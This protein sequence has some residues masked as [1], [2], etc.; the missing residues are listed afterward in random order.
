MLILSAVAL[1]ICLQRELGRQRRVLRYHLQQ[2][3]RT[4][5]GNSLLLRNGSEAKSRNGIL[6]HVQR[7]PRQLPSACVLLASR[8]RHSSGERALPR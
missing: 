7:T 5:S 2:C 8:A 4:R 1:D 6:Q 3:H